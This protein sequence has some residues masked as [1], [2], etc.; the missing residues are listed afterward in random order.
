MR[1][2]RAIGAG[3]AAFAMLAAAARVRPS[4]EIMARVPCGGYGE[5]SHGGPG[6]YGARGG[7]G[8]GPGGYGTFGG[9]GGPGA[10]GVRG[11]YVGRGAVGMPGRGPP[12]GGDLGDDRRRRSYWVGGRVVISVRRRQ[13][14][15]ASARIPG[16][17]SRPGGRGL[18]APPITRAMWWTITR[19]T[20]CAGRRLAI[21]G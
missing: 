15:Y 12:P 13:N 18:S 4:L 14:A 3:L 8:G 1:R 16:P 20:I 19:A 10:Y 7:F 2:S 11:A 5:Q 21:T 9:Y 17:A 6:G